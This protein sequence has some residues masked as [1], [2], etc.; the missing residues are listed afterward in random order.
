MRS[1]AMARTLS[2]LIALA[3]SS[4]PA[5]AAWNSNGTALRPGWVGSFESPV[6]ISIAPDDAG[7]AYVVFGNDVF[8]SRLTRLRSDGQFSA[9]WQPDGLSYSQ[10]PDWPYVPTVISDQNHGAFVVSVVQYCEA[11]CAGNLTELRA[12]HV[13]PTGEFAQGW[14]PDGVEIGSG[15]D[16]PYPDFD[17]RQT[18]VMPNG[19]GSALLT[20]AQTTTLDRGVDIFELRAQRVNADGSLPWGATGVS[21]RSAMNGRFQH[22]MV[23]DGSGGTYVFWADSRSPGVYAQHLSD[24][25]AALWAHDGVAVPLEPAAS[26]GRLVAVADG[27]RGAIVAWLGSSGGR[28]GIFVAH[29]GPG[30]ARPWH[31][32]RPVVTV[33]SES[34]SELRIAPTS[35]G[36]AVLA[37][38]ATNPDSSVAIRSQRLDREGRRVWPVQAVAVCAI[39]GARGPLALAPDGHD[40]AYLAWGDS[41]PDFAVYAMHLDGAGDPAAGWARNGTPIC[42]RRPSVASPNL[43]HSVTQVEITAVGDVG[44][45]RLASVSAGR[46]FDEAGG[47]PHERSVRTNASAIVAW[48][49][50]REGSCPSCAFTGLSPYA[51]MLGPTGPAI[52]AATIGAASEVDAATRQNP[53]V[54]DVSRGVALKALSPMRLR[55][56]LLDASAARLELFDVAGRQVWTRDVGLFGAGDHEITL[57]VDSRLANGVY[58]ARVTQKHA[59]A[60]TRVLIVR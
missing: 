36:G 25:G 50:D 48:V 58:L 20:W 42:A 56:S 7:G 53:L 21:V 60:S 57:D 51:L 24:S 1:I 14:T 35:S 17:V 55:L 5:W 44:R 32:E 10:Y 43:I 47:S 6:P 13:V 27:A 9:G 30:D 54:S 31:V 19:Q 49:D 22:A 28:S 23:S 52:P 26:S 18:Q 33:G 8:Q 40:G 59:V 45:R 41:R 38:L 37:W 39:P 11:H 4:E 16:R 29:V 2:L 34:L 15:A 12:Q 46:E 3:V